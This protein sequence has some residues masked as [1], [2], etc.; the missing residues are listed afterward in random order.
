MK[1]LPLGI[2]TFRNIIEGNYLYIDKTKD[3]FELFVNQGKYFFLSRPRRFGKSLLITTLEEIFLGNKELFKDLWIYDKIEWKKYP[4]IRIDF[5]N[6]LYTEGTNGFKDSF[7]SN[8]KWIAKSYQIELIEENYKDAFKELLLKLSKMIPKGSPGEEKVVLL[9]DEYDKPITNFVDDLEIAKK[10]RDILKSFYET[11]KACDEYIKFAFLTGVSKFA[12]VSVFSG[13]N[14]LTDITLDEKFSTI[15]GYTEEQLYFYFDNR[16]KLL[17][18]KLK[19]TPEEMKNEIKTWYNGYSWDGKD[20]VYNPYSILLLF[21]HLKMENYWFETATPTF[22]IKYIKEHN[23]S[24]KDIAPLV[25]DYTIFQS[26]EIDDFSFESFLFQTGYLTI[27]KI[28]EKNNFFKEYTLDYPNLEVKE[29]NLKE[30]MDLINI[31]IDQFILKMDND[32]KTVFNKIEDL[33]KLA[34]DSKI[35]Q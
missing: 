12:K 16:I 9:I 7:F 34:E 26:Y 22:L 11:I 33:N 13:L 20:F 35:D 24:I 28:E 32:L 1:N 19:I 29:L 21:S 8:I 30:E 25:T 2:Q 3:I 18:Q 14:N 31:R 23:I 17:S 10:N 4:V 15:T 5:S 27:K 6:M